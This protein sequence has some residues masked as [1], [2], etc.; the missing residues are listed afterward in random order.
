MT[1]TDTDNLSLEQ[2]VVAL[3]TKVE[4]LEK[5]RP[6]RRV[7]PNVISQEGVC[8]LDPTRN[9]AECTDASIYRYQQGC[10]GDCCDTI[11]TTYYKKY[12]AKNR[13][14]QQVVIDDDELDSVPVAF[15]T[16]RR[17]S[18]PRVDEAAGQD[19]GV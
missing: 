1:M 3:E 2:R 13:L 10:R 16:G 15:D 7:K 12:R 14:A 8:G 9:S 5:E 18:R 19:R 17:R 6:G 11:N 4:L